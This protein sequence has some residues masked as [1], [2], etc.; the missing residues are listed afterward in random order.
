MLKGQ[1]YNRESTVEVYNFSQALKS[2]SK[3]SNGVFDDASAN[4]FLT[5]SI[6]QNNGVKVPE[7]LQIVLDESSKKEASFITKAIL[8]GISTYE[9]SH[10][11]EMPADVLEQAIHSAYSVTKDASRYLDDTSTSSSTSE[12]SAAALQSNRAVVALL[13]T[14]TEAIPFAHYLPADIRSNQ[15]RLAIL[16]HEAGSDFGS[17]RKNDVLDGAFSGERYI[18][19]S[20]EHTL[21]LKDDKY[22]G[23]ITATQKTDS[24]C[25]PEAPKVPLL[26]GRSI[27][28]VNGRV[29]AREAN[30]TTGSGESPIVGTIDVAGTK[31]SLSGTINTDTG[32]VTGISVTPKFPEGVTVMVEAYVDYERESNLT[33]TLLTRVSTYDLF[34]TTWRVAARQTIDSRTQMQNELGLDPSAEGIISIQAQFGNER[35]YDVLRK[36]RRISMNNTDTYNFNWAKSGDF[37]LRADLWHDFSSVL[38]SVSQQMAILT[39]NHGVTHLYVGKKVAAQLTGLPNDIWQPS[40]ITA[41]AGIYRLGRLF[42]LY[43]VYYTPKVVREDIESAEILCI[44]QATDVTR[45]PF[46][47]GD[48]VAPTVIPLAVNTDLKT[49]AVYYARNF[50]AVNPHEHSAMGAALI[51]VTNLF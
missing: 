14:T 46:V 50:T 39:M 43:D 26:R 24:L 1:D 18:S 48:A 38:G 5:R 19:S 37:K 42:G 31:H 20:R 3:G 47:L 22:V 9:Q 6:N 11:Q 4:D 49:G 15:A 21:E 36:A 10:G 23:A 40:G 7:K 16:Q 35:H 25:D 51:T 29:A 17:Y 34:A 8:D 30:T 41:R 28:Y 13:T 33:P 32:V 12:A 44:G 45:N 2:E 27:V